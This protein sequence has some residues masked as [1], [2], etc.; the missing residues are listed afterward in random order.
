MTIKRALA[1]WMNDNGYGVFNTDLFLDAIPVEREIVAGWWIV[2]GG[3]APIVKN[4]SGEKTKAY[5]YSIFYRNTDS[6]D[7]D[8]KLQ[9]LE[10]AFNSKSCKELQG[11]ETIDVEA[12][13]LQSDGDLDGQDRT[14]GSIEVTITTYQ[15]E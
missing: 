8:T 1:Q 4:K 6:E 11:Y 12:T 7:V 9:A 10:E 13:G 3:G 14:I 5:I 2:G 15:S